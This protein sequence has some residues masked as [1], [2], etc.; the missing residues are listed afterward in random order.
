MG[1]VSRHVEEISDVS[2][3]SSLL[4]SEMV[5]HVDFSVKFL[6]LVAG[7]ILLHL[8]SRP[9]ISNLRPKF[10]QAQ[11]L[12]L[13]ILPSLSPAVVQKSFEG[14]DKFLA[15][16]D[17]VY[18]L[19]SMLMCAPVVTAIRPLIRFW[20]VETIIS[21]KSLLEE[22][23]PNVPLPIRQIVVAESM[24]HDNLS[25]DVVNNLADHCALIS[26]TQLLDKCRRADFLVELIC[27][28]S[29][30][31]LTAEEVR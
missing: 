24:R 31:N 7:E 6:D 20:P 8:E 2:L 4:M 18:F 13:T 17:R 16:L 23:L 15:C 9:Y 21:L 11:R 10:Y 12:F 19:R 25:S 14:M 27:C 30:R 26:G 3:A 1:P 28:G 29:L 5:S 22:Y